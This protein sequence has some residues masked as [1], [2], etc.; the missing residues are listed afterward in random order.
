MSAMA[1][2]MTDILFAGWLD[3]MLSDHEMTQSDLARK[4]HVTRGAI[5]G[6]L[7][8]ARGPGPD[9]CN[10]IAHAFGIPPEEVFREAGLLP[11]KSDADILTERALYIV[12]NFKYQ[13]TREL[14]ISLL[15]QLQLRE[16][17][18]E[19]SAKPANHPT[20]SESG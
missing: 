18:G 1:D 13:S 19:Y 2:K 17:K 8:G 14:A 11:L 6:I 4:A 7:S 5:N 12:S 10:A 9:L 16:L 20:P 3:K 15:E